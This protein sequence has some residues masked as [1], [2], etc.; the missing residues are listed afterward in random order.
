VTRGL[1]TLIR[2]AFAWRGG[3]AA[4]EL[5]YDVVVGDA[6]SG[7]LAD[8]TRATPAIV[9]PLDV[10]LP[11]LRAGAGPSRARSAALAWTLL[12]R[13]TGGYHARLPTDLS[14][15][16]GPYEVLTARYPHQADGLD[17]VLASLEAI[18]ALGV[19][20]GGP[21]VL[22]PA[23]L[24]GPSTLDALGRYE[25]GVL[26][27]D[28][29]GG[30]GH[31]VRAEAHATFTRGVLQARW[32]ALAA[33]SRMAVR[34]DE[35][36]GPR[37]DQASWDVGPA[38]F[39]P[40]IDEAGTAQMLIDVRSGIPADAFQPTDR[41]GA[42]LLIGPVEIGAL[43][44]GTGGYTRNAVSLALRATA[45]WTMMAD[46]TGGLVG[47]SP[48]TISGLSATYAGLF[49][50]PGLDHRK[51]MRAAQDF[52]LRTGLARRDDAGP[53]CVMVRPVGP[54][55]RSLHQTVQAL[56]RWILE[57][58]RTSAVL[59]EV[60]GQAIAYRDRHVVAQ[61]ERVLRRRAVRVAIRPLAA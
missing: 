20:P 46:A 32:R 39:R 55:Y 37:A 10:V 28:L 35:S 58:D 19:G 59:R 30:F 57:D 25:T 22:R 41:V 11:L 12:L 6:R 52:L 2:D 61:W 14:A 48:T 42:P 18:G 50:L 24:D 60:A 34:L 29:L 23:P 26:D 47:P 16:R 21:A 1:R 43:L 4:D 49:G 8:G 53:G 27:G 51:T 3:L 56:Y 5:E 44:L 40:R 31:R 54:D 15:V 38:Q 17:D 13:S 9:D 45:A 36:P 7:P 33:E